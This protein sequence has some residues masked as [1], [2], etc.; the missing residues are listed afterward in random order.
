MVDWTFKK[1][2]SAI[3]NPPSIP[4]SVL[5]SSAG[6]HLGDIHFVEL[7]TTLRMHAVS[8]MLLERLIAYRSFNPEH[9]AESGYS[10]STAILLTF[11]PD[12]KLKDIDG[13]SIS[14]LSTL[15]PLAQMQSAPITLGCQRWILVVQSLSW[16]CPP[17]DKKDQVLQSHRHQASAAMGSSASLEKSAEQN[18]NAD[19]KACEKENS[20]EIMTRAGTAI[21]RQIVAI[22][23][24]AGIATA[25]QVMTIAWP[26]SMADPMNLV[27]PQSVAIQRSNDYAVKVHHVAMSIDAPTHQTILSFQHLWYFI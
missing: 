14:T 6:R 11:V 21:T 5:E 7:C 2:L 10:H 27:I 20:I 19:C 4:T 23:R 3:K 9:M 16:I 22:Q 1:A 12:A 24:R 8:I 18:C 13:F 17:K 25:P 26:L 15:A